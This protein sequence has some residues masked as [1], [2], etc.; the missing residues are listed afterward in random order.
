MTPQV[1]HSSLG[2]IGKKKTCH[3]ISIAEIGNFSKK[4]E[5]DR[6]DEGDRAV[7]NYLGLGY[8]WANCQKYKC[9]CFQ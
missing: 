9:Q 5:R 7:Q 3:L 8:Y 4:Y 6:V 1:R 2:Y